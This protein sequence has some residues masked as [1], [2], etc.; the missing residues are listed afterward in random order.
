MVFLPPLD[1]DHPLDIALLSQ[2]PDAAYY[3]SL[4]MLRATMSIDSVLVAIDL[5]QRKNVRL[6][7]TA[8]DLEP[9]DPGFFDRRVT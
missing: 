7:L 4:V 9:N 5:P 2:W 1:G 6:F 8:P 3:Q